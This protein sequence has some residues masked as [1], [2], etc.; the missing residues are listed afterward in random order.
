MEH[1]K[2]ITFDTFFNQIIRSFHQFFLQEAIFRLDS[3]RLS[4]LILNSLL[5]LLFLYLSISS[6]FTFFLATV[7]LHLS[8]LILFSSEVRPMNFSSYRRLRNAFRLYSEVSR[9]FLSFNRVSL[10]KSLIL[11]HGFGVNSSATELIM[12]LL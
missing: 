8:R 3:F 6:N 2:V 7:T 10:G 1:I 12:N 11:N 4:P 5:L 9:S